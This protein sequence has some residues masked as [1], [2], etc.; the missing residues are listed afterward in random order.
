MI[1]LFIGNIDILYD[2]ILIARG[3]TGSRRVSPEPTGSL[4]MS[5]MSQYKIL[6][7]RSW[8][9]KHFSTSP[10][11]CAYP[12]IFYPASAQYLA[13]SAVSISRRLL[14]M[15][16]PLPIL[17]TI[18]AN[19]YLSG[20]FKHIKRPL[21]EPFIIHRAP[22]GQLFLPNRLYNPLS[23]PLPLFVSTHFQSALAISSIVFPMVIGYSLWWDASYMG[24][25]YRNLFE[26]ASIALGSALEDTALWWEMSLNNGNISTP[27]GD[28]E[29]VGALVRTIERAKADIEHQSAV[30]MLTENTPEKMV[31]WLAGILL[32]VVL[33]HSCVIDE[34]CVAE[35]GVW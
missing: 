17:G 28:S 3:H 19:K 33:A 23:L 21:T 32:A 8:Y 22:I 2:F 6:Q 5:Y 4:L 18:V 13:L 10:M 1:T 7:V 24:I 31:L 20:V 9:S 34:A 14:V 11:L 29:V 30:T 15:R 26:D 25:L 12:P 35:I 27:V 16:R